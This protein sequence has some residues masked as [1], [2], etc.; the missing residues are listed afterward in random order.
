MNAFKESHFTKDREDTNARSLRAGRSM[1]SQESEN[2]H[3]MLDS[4]YF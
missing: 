2:G 3:I 1:N 4:I